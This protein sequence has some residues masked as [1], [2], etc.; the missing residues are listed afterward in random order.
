MFVEVEVDGIFPFIF[1]F[2][3]RL[4]T[5]SDAM[6]P[7]CCQ[8]RGLSPRTDSRLASAFTR[9]SKVRSFQKKDPSSDVG[10]PNPAGKVKASIFANFC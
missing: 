9:L 7:S 1:A 10:S 5:S 2:I 8:I 4:G 6:G 3:E